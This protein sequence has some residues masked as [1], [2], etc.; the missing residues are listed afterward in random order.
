[1]LKQI[2]LSVSADEENMTVFQDKIA[3]I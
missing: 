1:L 3:L 2:I